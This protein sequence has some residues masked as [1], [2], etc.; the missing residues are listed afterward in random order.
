MTF[1]PEGG[2]AVTEQTV[3]YGGKVSEP[4]QPTKEGHTFVGWTYNG[5]TWDFES[6]TMPASDIELVAQWKAN[7]YTVTFDPNGGTAVTEQTVAYGGKAT[8]PTAP[9]RTGYTFLGW[10]Y[11]GE[12]WDFD[13]DT[14]P[15]GNI[16][17]VAKWTANTYKIVFHAN[18][19]SETTKEQSVTYDQK[20][21]LES[22]SFARNGYT[23][24]GWA[25]SENGAIAYLDGATVI[26][27][28]SES[29]ERRE[30]HAVRSLDGKHLYRDVRPRRRHGGDGADGR[31][32]RQGLRARTADQGRAYLRGMDV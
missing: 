27:L 9:T 28:A 3:A 11:N 22:N 30:I 20:K 1:D 6:D 13:S 5:K 17:L 24:A 12:S 8:Q 19:G 15:A 14:V 21:A 32:R 23:F 7:E 31:I 4:A 26:N 2:T 10:T 18:D 16:T 29:G 25:T